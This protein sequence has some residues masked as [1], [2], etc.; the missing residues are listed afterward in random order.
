MELMLIIIKETLSM[1]LLLGGM[2]RLYVL[3]LLD[4]GAY[5]DEDKGGTTPTPLDGAAEGSRL[6]VVRLLL[7]RG[8]GC[9]PEQ[10]ACAAT[11]WTMHGN[12]VVR[13]LLDQGAQVMPFKSRKR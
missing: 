13:L 12:G 6:E 9:S 11:G 7:E 1:R 5:V 10:C 3:L 4:R 8:G 2:K